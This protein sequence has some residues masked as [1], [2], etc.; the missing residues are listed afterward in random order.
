MLETKNAGAS[1]H[2]DEFKSLV[3]TASGVSATAF[4]ARGGFAQRLHAGELGAARGA[5][6][7][8]APDGSASRERK[9]MRALLVREAEVTASLLPLGAVGLDAALPGPVVR[10]Q[11]GELMAESSIDFRSAELREARVQR[12]EAFRPIRHPCRAPHPRIPADPDTCGQCGRTRRS[13]Q[14]A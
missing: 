8:V 9:V 6:I 11:M 10:E 2:R 3:V 1:F 14:L 13:E 5:F 12:D 4:D 7:K